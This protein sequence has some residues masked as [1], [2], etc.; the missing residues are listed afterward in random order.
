MLRAAEVL[1][2]RAPSTQEIFGIRRQ[3]WSNGHRV[4]RTVIGRHRLC[5]LKDNLPEGIRVAV[6]RTPRGDVLIVNQIPQPCGE[7]E[8][9]GIPN[10]D[11][12]TAVF[13]YT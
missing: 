5:V 3:R 4:Y 6:K 2:L 8:A 10:V 13:P 11:V 7:A 1:G 9:A 12:T